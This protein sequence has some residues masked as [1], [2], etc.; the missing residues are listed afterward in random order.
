MSLIG[1]GVDV[2][3][4]VNKGANADLY[5]KLGKFIDRANDLQAKVEELEET[6]KELNNRLRVNGSLFHVYGV[7][8][9][10]DDPYPLCSK[11]YEADRL[12]I[13]LNITEHY[14]PTCPNCKTYYGK[15]DLRDALRGPKIKFLL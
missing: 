15:A 1:D 3:K 10:Q 4:L 9:I 8:F 12:L 13:H 14:V 11:C 7:L 2:L 5:E 6:N